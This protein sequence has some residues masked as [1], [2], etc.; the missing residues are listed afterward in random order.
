MQKASAFNKLI[1]LFYSFLKLH[2]MERSVYKLYLAAVALLV[3]FTAGCGNNQSES[4]QTTRNGD[5]TGVSNAGNDQ[6]TQM[7]LRR[8]DSLDFQFYNNQ[9]WDSFTISHDDNIKV[10][11]PDGS[12]TTGIFPQHI[13]KLEPQFAFAP[14]TKITNHPVMF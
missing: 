5:T 8:F 10:Y 12:T 4:G 13:D 6:L 1:T 7:R 11:Y 3:L 9:R 2:A 14:D